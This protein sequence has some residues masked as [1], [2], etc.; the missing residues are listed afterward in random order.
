[1]PQVFEQSLFLFIY[2][3]NLRVK[4]QVQHRGGLL[5]DWAPVD[6]FLGMQQKQGCRRRC[7]KGLLA[8]SA[9]DAIGGGPPQPSQSIS[10]NNRVVPRLFLIKYFF[11]LKLE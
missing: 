6:F 4:V 10:K 9:T 2:R 3:P 11:S 5:V 8:M 7:R 1:M